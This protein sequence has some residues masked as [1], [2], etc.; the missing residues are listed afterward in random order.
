MHHWCFLE[1]ATWAE[2][3]VNKNEPDRAGVG[4]G[5]HGKK[6]AKG[7]EE[8]ENM[9][10]YENPAGMSRRASQGGEFGVGL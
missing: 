5:R 1:E 4:N 8:R 6:Q 10:P 3:R 7:L 9:E 2:Q